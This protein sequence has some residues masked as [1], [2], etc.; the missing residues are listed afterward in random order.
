MKYAVEM[1]SGASFYICERQLNKACILSSR[2]VHNVTVLKHQDF[3][4]KYWFY[5]VTVA[6]FQAVTMCIYCIFLMSSFCME[7]GHKHDCAY[8]FRMYIVY[9]SAI[10]RQVHLTH[11]T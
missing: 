4:I 9:T 5:L 11:F 2:W 6:D 8:R 7:R 1:S 3:G 10:I